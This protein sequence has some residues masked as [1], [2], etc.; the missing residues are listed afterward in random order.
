MPWPE[1]TV[2]KFGD[3]D[4]NEDLSYSI[5]FD[6]AR[7]DKER[8]LP[9]S[10]EDQ[11]DTPV[12]KTP[13]LTVGK[14]TSHASHNQRLGMGTS[15]ARDNSLKS[16]SGQAFLTGSRISGEQKISSSFEVDLWNTSDSGPTYRPSSGQPMPMGATKEAKVKEGHVY[17]DHVDTLHEAYHRRIQSKPAIS[18]GPGRQIYQGN[19]AA[20][21]ITRSQRSSE[22]SRT[23]DLP[24]KV[25]VPRFG[26]WDASDSTSGEGFTVIFNR[27]R[28]EKRSKS[29]P[30]TT[31]KT[32]SPVRPDEDLYKNS[33]MTTSGK[34]RRGWLNT[35]CCLHPQPYG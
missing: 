15:D 16:P 27:A 6:K 34:K 19:P 14:R 25:V 30:K 8:F 2:P 32:V 18:P 10:K 11:K 17:T 20:A 3:W 7:A 33:Q 23:D 35:V 5:V 9:M 1:T 21:R 13:E 24:E 4:N 28:D 12:F 31:G 29:T 22:S 26:D